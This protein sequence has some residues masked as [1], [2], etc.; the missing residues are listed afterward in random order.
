ME[1]STFFGLTS[2]DEIRAQLGAGSSELNNEDIANLSVED[3]LQLDL[4]TWFPE[5]SALLAD[6]DAAVKS[7][8]LAIK[9]Y[10]KVFCASRV[11]ITAPLRFLQKD[12]N[13][14]NANSRFQNDNSLNNFIQA[15]SDKVVV[16][17]TKVL[18]FTTAHSPAA[19]TVTQK[20]LGMSISTPS[21]NVITR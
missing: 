4:L 18:S 13:G 5:Y 6:T 11:V 3:E 17:K 19:S 20:Y 21:V 9:I 1:E 12:G 2:C 16:S 14:D 7:Q 15:L 10:A 8:K